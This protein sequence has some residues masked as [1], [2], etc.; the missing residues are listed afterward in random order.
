MISKVLMY[1]G[2]TVRSC[3]ILYKAVAQTVLRYGSEIWVA[4]G[5]MLKVLEEF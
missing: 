5:S 3:G 1:T 4:T 2:A